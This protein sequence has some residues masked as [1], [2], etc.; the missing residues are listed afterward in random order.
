[1]RVINIEIG[2]LR[3]LFLM[4]EIYLGMGDFYKS[5]SESCSNGRCGY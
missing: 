4:S 1:M 5:K 2:I 3:N